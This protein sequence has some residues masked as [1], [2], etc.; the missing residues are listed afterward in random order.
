MVLDRILV[1]NQACG[2]ALA[3]AAGTDYNPK[4]HANFC[5]V[6]G[7]MLVGGVLF[8]GYTGESIA[9]HMAG[10]D[11]HWVNRDMLFMAYDYPFNQLGVKRLFGLV[12]ESNTTALGIDLKMGFRIV[13][14][15]EG[16]YR[17]N[18]AC[19]VLCM[20]RHECRYLGI[21]PRNVVSNKSVN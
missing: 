19:M 11:T 5:R 1:N 15:I 14:R 9:I 17:D 12:P 20:E 16:V 21:K 2:E 10:W 6:K 18:V 13:N 3:K 4:A 8:S 7:D